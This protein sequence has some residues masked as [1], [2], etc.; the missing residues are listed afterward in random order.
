MHS[1]RRALS[2]TTERMRELDGKRTMCFSMGYKYEGGG[3][4]VCDPKRRVVVESIYL[5]FADRRPHSTIRVHSPFTRTSLLYNPHLTTPLNCQRCQLCQRHPRRS[6]HSRPHQRQ[7]TSMDQ[8][9]HLIHAST[10]HNTSTR[11]LDET[12]SYGI[13]RR[14]LLVRRL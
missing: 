7:R 5:V 12:T 2:L 4:Q 9:R 14:I 3:Y 8:R 1:A 13:Q 6:Y 10:H 11:A